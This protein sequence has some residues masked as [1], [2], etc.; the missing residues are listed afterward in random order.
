MFIAFPVVF[1]RK[2]KF[3]NEHYSVRAYSELE[4]VV[5][6]GFELVLPGP[7]VH[8]LLVLD[9]MAQSADERLP[10]VATQ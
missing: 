4:G 1:V 3:R 9:T 8:A 7:F 5:S 2:S 6:S 10:H